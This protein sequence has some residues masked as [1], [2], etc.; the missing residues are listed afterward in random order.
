[1]V[2]YARSLSSL[3]DLPSLLSVLVF[4]WRHG[5]GSQGS[6]SGYGGA[7]WDRFERMLHRRDVRLGKKRGPWSWSDKARQGTKI[8]AIVDGNGLPIA[9]CVG[10]ASPHEVTLVE[11]VLDSKYTIDYPERIS[12]T[13]PT[14]A[15]R[16]TGGSKHQSGNHSLPTERRHKTEENSENTRD[17]GK[18]IGSLHG[19]RTSGE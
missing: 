1:M 14:I 11:E 13:K 15:I 8:M 10:S 2:G 9:L 12:V 18:L 16:S 5:L 4:E 6:G 17:V 19:F 3:P 7:R